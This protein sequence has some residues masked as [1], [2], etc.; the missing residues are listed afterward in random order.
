MV[1]EA[2][3][4]LVVGS[5]LATFSA[6][7]LARQM[8]EAGRPIGIVNVGECRGDA[9]AA[10]RIGLEEG[11]GAVLPP[12]VKTLLADERRQDIKD[13][14]DTMLKSGK[15]KQVSAKHATT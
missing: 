5:S 3:Q 9:L 4:L 15:I 14:V 10:W 1:A 2:S 8:N 6:F 7:R 13:E 12:A 11:S